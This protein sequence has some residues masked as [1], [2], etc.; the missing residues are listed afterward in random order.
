VKGH[1]DTQVYLSTIVSSPSLGDK[2]LSL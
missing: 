2:I 1:A